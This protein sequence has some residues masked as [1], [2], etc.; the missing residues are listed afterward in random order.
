LEL[1]NLKLATIFNMKLRLPALTIVIVLLGASSGISQT[2]SGLSFLKFGTSAEG[3]AMAEAMT[4]S[5]EGAFATYYNPAG[6]AR[7]SPNAVA[8]S[9]NVWVGN[10]RTY[11]AAAR[12]TA[13]QSGGWGA[14]VTA[15]SNGEIEARRGPSAEPD[16]LISAQFVG[17]GLS[18]GRTIG[19]VRAGVTAKYLTERIAESVANGYALDAGVQ[20]PML[21]ERVHL[22]AAIQHFGRMEALASEASPLPETIRAGISLQPFRVI[23]EDDDVP[24]LTTM[25]SAEVVHR[26]QEKR[27]Q[28]HGGLAV[29][30]FQ[31]LTLRS[32]YLSN[33]EFRRFSLGSGLDLE[34]LQF[35]YSYLPFEDNFGTGHVL[36]LAYMW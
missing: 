28:I 15:V 29:E 18:Y 21:E 4:A 9:H 24:F 14:M 32:G 10:T 36:T 30:L 3:L 35:D 23:T 17:V 12:F 8:A 1:E 2:Q 19:P 7:S 22:G 31:V 16:G 33:N 11:N 34:T 20:L 27:T 26:S 5:A 25:V 13:G 6:L